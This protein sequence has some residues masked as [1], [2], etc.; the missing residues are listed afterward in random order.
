[1]SDNEIFNQAD[2][3]YD[4]GNFKEAFSLFRKS[5]ENGNYHA[6]SRLACMY[7]DGEGT[8]CNVD[9]SIAWDL[10]AIKSGSDISQLNLAITYRTLGDIKESKKW[11]E[12]A[13]NAGDGEAALQLAKLYMVSDKE[14]ATVRKY[15]TTAIESDDLFDDSLEEAGK[16]LSGLNQIK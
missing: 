2:E 7:S 8:E 13:V 11:F 1:M 4:C 3:A 5:A 15:L 10:K 6:M 12:K 9:E 14:T 16:L